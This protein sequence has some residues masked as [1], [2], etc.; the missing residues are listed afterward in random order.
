M[1]REHGLFIGRIHERGF[2]EELESFIACGG[3]VLGVS[4]GSLIFVNNLPDNLGLLP[5]RLDVH[6]NDAVREK[7][8]RYPIDVK[9]PIKLGNRQAILLER[10]AFDVME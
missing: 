6:C 4:A 2:R 1:W 9:R 8:G 5:F 10:E 7:P 3:V